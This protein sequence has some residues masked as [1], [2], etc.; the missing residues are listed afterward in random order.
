MQTNR[1]TI[2]PEPAPRLRVVDGAL[3]PFDAASI[4]ILRTQ[5]L[6]MSVVRVCANDSTV[7]DSRYGGVGS[8]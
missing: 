6:R 1:H 5:T 7:K 3:H 4:D 8:I 2:A